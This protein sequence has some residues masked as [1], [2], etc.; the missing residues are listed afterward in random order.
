MTSSFMTISPGASIGEA[1]AAMAASGASSLLV[2]GEKRE[3]LGIITESDLMQRE[4]LGHT[5]HTSLWRTLFTDDR[6][7]ARA[8]AKSYGRRVGEVM[9]CSLRTVT[10]HTSVMQAA[11]ALYSLDVK[12]LPVMRDGEVVGVVSRSDVIRALGRLGVE[13]EAETAADE[14]IA[15]VIGTRIGRAGWVS[16]QQ[17][18]YAVREGRVEYSGIVT[19]DDQRRALHAL[20]HGVPGVREVLDR[21]HIT[22]KLAARPG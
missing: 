17:V 21:L 12:Q 2:L 22:D 6:T 13:L 9:S 8:F 16:P 4:A 11:E 14:T 10:E 19:S 15:D 7:L 1:A 3:A 20:A 5:P 18:R